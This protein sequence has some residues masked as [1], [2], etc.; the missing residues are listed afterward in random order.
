MLLLEVPAHRSSSD[1]S[2]SCH[3]TSLLS[4]CLLWAPLTGSVT[5]L[6]ITDTVTL[7][8]PM[9]SLITS[10]AVKGQVASCP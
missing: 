2:A 6:P 4:S 1:S 7:E 8:L 5:L 9:R 3:Y 10:P